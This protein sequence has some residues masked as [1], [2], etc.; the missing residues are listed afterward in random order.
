MLKHRKNKKNRVISLFFS[1]V[2]VALISV[3]IVHPNAASSARISIATDYDYKVSD[4]YQ[5][6]CVK[7]T[8]SIVSSL[9]Y[10]LNYF[11]DKTA[12]INSKKAVIG[13][14]AIVKTNNKWGHV[15]Y[16]ENV[17]GSTIT[18]LDS[19]WY[20]QGKTHIVR[21][22]GSESALGI[23]GYYIPSNLV[24][25]TESTSKTTSTTV[26]KETTKAKSTT[27]AKEKKTASSSSKVTAK[28]AL[29][30]S[31]NY[32][33]KSGVAVYSKITKNKTDKVSAAGLYLW[34][35]GS[36]KPSKPL[37]KETF[38]KG[39]TSQTSVKIYYRP[40]IAFGK[41]LKSKTTYNYQ[42]YAVVNGKTIT[43]TV[44]SITTK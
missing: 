30:T 10:G 41:K 5:Y 21:R 44:G 3:M 27:A 24:V 13:A 12:I 7:F 32:R 9:P 26:S 8:R 2:I 1:L 33:T 23:V 22:T 40:G 43:T 29:T 11:E 36:K 18:T 25:K 17:N 16:V 4:L 31:L 38:S 39:F 15:A 19:N 28:I 6:N 20:Y 14:V 37:T 35:K 42:I 34:E